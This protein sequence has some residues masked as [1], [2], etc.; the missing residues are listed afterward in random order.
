MFDVGKSRFSSCSSTTSPRRPLSSKTHL[1]VLCVQTGTDAVDLLVQLGT[2]M[3]TLLTGTRHSEGDTT[4]MPSTDTGDLAQTLV[5]L[6]RQFLCVPTA[7]DTLETLTLGDG[8]A[9]DHLVLGKHLGHGNGLLQVLLHP[10]DLVLDGATVQLDL[11]QVSLLLALLDQANLWK[12]RVKGARLA[13]VVANFIFS[14][15]LLSPCICQQ[16]ISGKI[17]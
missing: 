11:H 17:V 14:V 5:R 8:N 10:V 7:G 6:A 13:H 12:H 1:S 4:W 15:V 16:Q 9:I 3:V 2:V